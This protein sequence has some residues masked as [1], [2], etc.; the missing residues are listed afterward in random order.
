M[1][2]EPRYPCLAFVKLHR[3]GLRRIQAFS[4]KHH[5]HVNPTPRASMRGV[6]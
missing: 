3:V 5:V 2:Y 4:H 1:G 6:G